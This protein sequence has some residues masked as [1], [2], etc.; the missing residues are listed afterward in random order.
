MQ[1]YLC[2]YNAVYR[3][4]NLNF[5]HKVYNYSV[6]FYLFRRMIVMSSSG[7]CDSQ[8]NSEC[9]DRSQLDRIALAKKGD[10]EFGS[11]RPCVCVSLG[12]SDLSC[13]NP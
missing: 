9:T 6:V 3:K 12:L 4:C 10:Y 11:I 5:K 2:K 1:M 7:M 13:L 8:F